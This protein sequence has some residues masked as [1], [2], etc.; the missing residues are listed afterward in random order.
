MLMKIFKITSKSSFLE[1]GGKTF[2]EGEV[3]LVDET[4]GGKLLRNNEGKFTNEIYSLPLIEIENP[5]DLVVSTSADMGTIIKPK[6][7]IVVDR[8]L[9]ASLLNTCNFLIGKEH[10]P[11]VVKP[12]VV[13]KRKAVKESAKKEKSIKI[14]VKKI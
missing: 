12:K 10:K 7:S 4:R 8:F 13:G 3:L 5:S 14:K 1:S 11:K 2:K 9:G 6:S